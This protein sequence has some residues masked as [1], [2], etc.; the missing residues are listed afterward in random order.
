MSTYPFVPPRRHVLEAKV[1]DSMAIYDARGFAD[2]SVITLRP[3]NS[4]NSPYEQVP[5]FMIEVVVCVRARTAVRDPTIRRIVDSP[6]LTASGYAG[7][8]AQR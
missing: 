7:I 1:T 2:I 8:R 4:E 3:E 5:L 6:H